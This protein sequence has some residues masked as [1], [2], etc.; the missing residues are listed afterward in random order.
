MHGNRGAGR[1]GAWGWRMLA[2]ALFA[3]AP[4]GWAL[5]QEG[6]PSTVTNAPKDAAAAAAQTAATHAPGTP[7]VDPGGG[8]FH[9]DREAVLSVVILVFGILVLVVQYLL[10]R[11]PPRRSSFEILQLLSIN[12]I[13]TGT[14]FLISAGF[15]AQQIA[16]GLGLFGTIAGYVLGRRS[17]ASDGKDPKGDAE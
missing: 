14:L 5:A 9:T 11:V 13:I 2:V 16:P 3:L 1:P 15:G 6:P 8:V 17:N 12:L 10:L 7:E 4:M